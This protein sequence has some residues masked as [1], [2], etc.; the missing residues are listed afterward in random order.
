VVVR[1]GLPSHHRFFSAVLVSDLL[2]G[3]RF[4]VFNPPSSL[5]V[6]S[7]MLLGTWWFFLLVSVKLVLLPPRGF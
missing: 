7:S 3:V 4:A 1:Q 5:P 6:G 2:S